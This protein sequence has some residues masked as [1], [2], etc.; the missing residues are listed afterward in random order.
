MDVIR[1]QTKTSSTAKEGQH[2][3]TKKHFD[4]YRS[5]FLDR[6]GAAAT[7]PETKSTNSSSGG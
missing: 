5:R 4:K 3:N 1:A 7:E 2:C 6:S